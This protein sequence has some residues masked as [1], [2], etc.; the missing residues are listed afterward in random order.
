LALEAVV[1][2]E[3]LEDLQLLEEVVLVDRRAVHLHL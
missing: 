1:A 2:A 3:E